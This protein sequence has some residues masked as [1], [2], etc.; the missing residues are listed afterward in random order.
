VWNLLVRCLACENTEHASLPCPLECLFALR[1]TLVVRDSFPQ[2]KS[3]TDKTL[4]TVTT[5]RT[6]TKA[7]TTECDQLPRASSTRETVIT[8]VTS[9]GICLKQFKTK[10]EYQKSNRDPPKNSPKCRIPPS[11]CADSWESF[12]ETFGYFMARYGDRVESYQAFRITQLTNHLFTDCPD[13]L[14]YL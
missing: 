14:P 2:Q 10:E 7:A 13:V 8:T 12:N 1:S 4:F 3:C 6:L 11:D 5:T 9:A